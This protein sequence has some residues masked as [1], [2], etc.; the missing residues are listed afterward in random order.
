MVE[1]FDILFRLLLCYTIFDKSSSTIY[2]CNSQAACGCSSNAVSVNRIVGGENATK[3]AWGWVASIAIGG[4]YLCGGSILSKSWIIT[5]AHCVSG[6]VPSQ[7]T[8]YVGSTL[9]WSGTQSQ[10]AAEIVVHS[11]YNSATFTNDIALIRLASPLTMPDPDIAPICV[12]S[13]SAQ[14][15][16]STEW[17]KAGTSV[18][19]LSFLVLSFHY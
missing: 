15:L 3:A 19:L 2:S 5:A 9:R 16:S 13:V 17:P 8:V 18:L 1:C 10:V 11:G 12:P 6:V 14:T 7:V 4:T